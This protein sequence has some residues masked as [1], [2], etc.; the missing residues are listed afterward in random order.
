[1]ELKGEDDDKF[2]QHQTWGNVTCN[3]WNDVQMRPKKTYSTE[4]GRV[5]PGGTTK[6]SVQYLKISERNVSITM[7]LL[8]VG[9][10]MM[11]F[12]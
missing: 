9:K 10:E 7:N 4:K 1:M 3:R 6:A 2:S 8:P 11:H 5:M 12:T